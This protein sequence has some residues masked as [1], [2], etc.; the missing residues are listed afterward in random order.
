[1]KN[2][3]FVVDTNI[4]ISAVLFK[5]SGIRK[6]FDNV[7]ETGKIAASLETF[8][9]FR[10]ILLRPKFDRYVSLESKLSVLKDFEE[11]LIFFEISESMQSCRDPKDN[12]FL[13]LAISANATC[14]ITGDKDLL[15][16]HP[17]RG[18]PI[19]YAVDFLLSF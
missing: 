19:L 11:M 3:I 4:L 13:E 2:N 14:I 5:N 1:M 7:I 6:T 15:V 8:S 9:E 10:E 18:I 17:F 16:L 12:K